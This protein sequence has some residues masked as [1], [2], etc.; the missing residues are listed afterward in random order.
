MMYVPNNNAVINNIMM[1]SLIGAVSRGGGQ[2]GPLGHG[3]GS[4]GAA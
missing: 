4:G 2:G 1:L 3:S